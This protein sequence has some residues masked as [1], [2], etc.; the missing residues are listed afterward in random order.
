MIP[1][2][3]SDLK[4]Y[5]LKVCGAHD[6]IHGSDQMINFTYIRQC[7]A[8]DQKINLTLFSTINTEIYTNELYEDF[9]LIEDP[10]VNLGTHAQLTIEG[11]EEDQIRTISLWDLARNFR[12]QIVAC[13]NLKIGAIESVY[14]EVGVYF[15][16]EPLCPVLRTHQVPASRDP[17][18]GTL[19]NFDIPCYNLPRAARLCLTVWGRWNARK[20]IDQDRESDIYPLGWVN[21]LLMDFKGFLRTGLIKL[22]LWPNDKANPIG[23]TTHM[24][25]TGDQ[26]FVF[27]KLETYAHPVIF[28]TESF[29]NDYRDRQQSIASISSEHADRIRYLIASD[30]LTKLSDG[31]KEIIWKYR[32]HLASEPTSLPKLLLSTRWNVLDHVIEIRKLMNI[33]GPLPADAALELLDANY[34]DATVR[35]FAVK[36]LESLSDSELLDFLLQLVQ[37]LKYE[38]YLDNALSRFL[39]KRALRSKVVGH[40]F[41]WYLRVSQRANTLILTYHLV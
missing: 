5:C 12:A 9:N 41:F 22:A 32:H 21:M 14:V 39:L 36:H 28:P 24:A 40:Y 1:Y 23:T 38:P 19:L 10:C 26:A 25:E 17:R 3:F 6:F 30:P 4:T 29:S 7:L 16:G 15:G 2:L 31:D 37:A 20:K 13:E 35:A 18:W 11:Q 33:W 8:K 27:L 34:G